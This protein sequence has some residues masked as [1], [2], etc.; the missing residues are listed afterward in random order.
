MMND[1]EWWCFIIA[2]YDMVWLWFIWLSMMK[3]PL[4]VQCRDNFWKM[5][6]CRIAKPEQIFA[7]L[8]KIRFWSTKSLGQLPAYSSKI[9]KILPGTI[10]ISPGWC[11]RVCDHRPEAG[12]EAGRHWTGTC[13]W[14]FGSCTCSTGEGGSRGLSW[15]G[16]QNARARDF[17]RG[18]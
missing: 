16:W 10:F 8:N 6:W 7:S 18:S 5:P 11:P 15:G 3:L 12:G 13:D 17:V 1:D 2:D 9:S 14:S 4:Y